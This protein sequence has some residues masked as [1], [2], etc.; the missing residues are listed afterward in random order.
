MRVGMLMTPGSY[1]L[2]ALTLPASGPVDVPHRDG[3]PYGICQTPS[4][5]V[6]WTF[7]VDY[8]PPTADVDGNGYVNADDYDLW[9]I[10][11]TAGCPCSD[12][13]GKGF[14]NGDDADLF[15]SEF[16]SGVTP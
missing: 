9:M 3:D 14:V 6:G 5:W 2:H 15:T 13:D 4:G 10:G 11:Y 7:R 12:F 16:V 1:I 8:G